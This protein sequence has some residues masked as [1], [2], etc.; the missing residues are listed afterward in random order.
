MG[1]H[2]NSFET[3][4]SGALLALCSA[5]AL[6][7]LTTCRSGLVVVG[8]VFDSRCEAD[9]YSSAEDDACAS[10]IMTC[11]TMCDASQAPH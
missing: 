11:S 10:H 4:A 1:V 3:A 8:C 2:N 6:I 5:S 7:A 9:A